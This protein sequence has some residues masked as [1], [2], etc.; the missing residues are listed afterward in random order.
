MKKKKIYTISIVCDTELTT[1]V[2]QLFKFENNIEFKKIK[3]NTPFGTEIVIN[4]EK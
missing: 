3:T 4:M 1:D 2:L